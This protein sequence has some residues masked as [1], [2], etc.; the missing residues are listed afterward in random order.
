MLGHVPEGTGNPL[1]EIVIRGPLAKYIAARAEKEGVDVEEFLARLVAEELDEDARV[2]LYLE[3]HQERLS[4]AEE[5]EREG[6]LV[7]AGEKLWGA[8]CSLLSA[9]A[10]LRGWRHFSHR[11]YCDIVERLVAELS[12]PE[13]S[14]EFASAERPHA[15]YY[16]AFLRPESFK[17]HRDAVLKLMERLRGLLAGRTSA[18]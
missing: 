16:H 5:L 14:K 4:E 13:L 18:A 8:V 17:A 10:E 3:L 7:R 6:D 15:N 12:E 2:G 9:I 1:L 11:D